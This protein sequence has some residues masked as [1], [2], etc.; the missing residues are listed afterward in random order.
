[1][2]GYSHRENCLRL[3]ELLQLCTAQE[4]MF[5][6]WSSLWEDLRSSYDRSINAWEILSKNHHCAWSASNLWKA[7]IKKKKGSW[8]L[9]QCVV[10]ATGSS[11]TA[12]LRREQARGVVET[13]VITW[14]FIVRTTAKWQLT[15]QCLALE[16]HPGAL[17]RKMLWD[18]N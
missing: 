15:Y 8:C 1:M 16:D 12:V 6:G 11:G 9:Q 14:D 17:Q 5:C 18:T 3:P 13:V 2:E 4:H 7:V 10:T